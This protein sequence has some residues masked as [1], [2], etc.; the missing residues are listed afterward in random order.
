ME[1]KIDM[2]G[3]E[4]VAQQ[5]LEKW[6]AIFRQDSN[7][8]E[9]R[10]AV[11]ESIEA[12]LNAYLMRCSQNWIR[13]KANE[14]TWPAFEELAK[15]EAEKVRQ[16]FDADSG[17]IH[18]KIKYRIEKNIL[19]NLERK[20]AFLLDDEYRIA[21]DAVISAAVHQWIKSGDLP[22]KIKPPLAAKQAA[23]TAIRKASV[24]EYR[25]AFESRNF[26]VSILKL[27][28]MKQKDIAK[29]FDISV[30]RV[31]QITARSMPFGKLLKA[32]DAAGFEIK[33]K[34]KK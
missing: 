19:D 1:M 15:R 31:G 29:K 20:V 27:A 8:A 30:A 34:N 17:E 9:F 26:E 3:L 16:D 21:F 11:S 14:V 25:E 18:A 2:G 12:E 23:I 5:T 24:D 32:L 10:E 4:L 6:V 7:V 33:K 28:G 13:E 22:L